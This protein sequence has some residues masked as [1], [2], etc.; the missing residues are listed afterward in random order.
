[1]V[2]GN[3]SLYNETNGRAIHPTPVVGAVG[4]VEDVRLIPKGWRE[5]DS[6]LVA[7]ASPLSLA[8]SEYQACFGEVS[9]SPAPLDLE[10]EARLV[11]FLWRAAP[12]C[13]LVHDASE[14]GLAV[15]LAEAAIFSGVGASPAFEY[16]TLALF[17][18]VGGRAVLACALEVRDEVLRL[19]HELGV[20][21]DSV[22]LAEGGTLFGMELA[23]L[24]AAWAGSDDTAGVRPHGSD[25]SGGN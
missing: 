12:L 11:A 17:G 19:A 8:G 24:H 1:V 9:G 7:G 22:G 4:L 10:A 13:S 2:S 20:P 3:V 5:G 21:V 23:R 16:G 6:L 25:P 14:G 15:C 18:E